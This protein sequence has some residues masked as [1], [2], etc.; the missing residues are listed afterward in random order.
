MVKE[1]MFK[2]IAKSCLSV[3]AAKPNTETKITTTPKISTKRTSEQED[4]VV[5]MMSAVF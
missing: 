3:L 5:D 2:Q 1:N 4:Q